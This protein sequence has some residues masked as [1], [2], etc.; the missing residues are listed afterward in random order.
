MLPTVYVNIIVLSTVLGEFIERA[1][2]F[3]AETPC[4]SLPPDEIVQQRAI[5]I[6]V[7]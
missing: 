1:M 3:G 6:P 2:E 5:W 7:F 4:F